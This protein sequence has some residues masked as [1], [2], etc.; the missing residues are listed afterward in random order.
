MIE[1]CTKALA[2]NPEHTD[3]YNNRG[4]AYAGKGDIDRAIEDF[5]TALAV[6]PRNVNAYS[7]R[8]TLW[9][10]LGEWKKAEA[11]LRAAK[12]MGVDIPTIFRLNYASVKDFEAEH[13]VKLPRALAVLLSRG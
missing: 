6:N 1:E 12:G 13:R 10:H 3:A 11:D 9:L 7:N 5:N 2:L 4:S 8:G